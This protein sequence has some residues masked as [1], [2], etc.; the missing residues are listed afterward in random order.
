VYFAT[1]LEFATPCAPPPPDRIDEDDDLW[2]EW[3]TLVKGDDDRE[4]EEFRECGGVRF[5]PPPP[6]A[7][8]KEDPELAPLPLPPPNKPVRGL[9]G[10]DSAASLVVENGPSAAMMCAWG[11]GG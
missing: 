11:H 2:C 6:P 5:N 1:A 8:P 3:W 7:L 4:R 9:N 10:G